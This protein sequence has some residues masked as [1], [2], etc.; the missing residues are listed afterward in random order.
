MKKSF[1]TLFVLLLCIVQSSFAL[2]D[3]VLVY[4]PSMKKDIKNVIVT[5]KDYDSKKTYPV[6]YLLHGHGG[7]H[8]T[9]I[10]KT[11]PTLEEDV[12]QLGIIAVCPDGENSWYVDSPIDS[13]YKYETY[14]IEEEKY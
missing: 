9:W 4:S 5:P 3:T 6:V 11:K 2:V 12:T 1:L 14:I 7:G 10:T 8:H 13:S